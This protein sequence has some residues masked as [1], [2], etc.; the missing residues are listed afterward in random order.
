MV[1]GRVCRK[2]L[3]ASRVSIMIVSMVAIDGVFV[4]DGL[5]QS[6]MDVN[7]RPGCRSQ[8]QVCQRM[9]VV[10]RAGTTLEVDCSPL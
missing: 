10:R 6:K 8:S 1:E 2:T 3:R 4:L 9:A 7:D 5:V